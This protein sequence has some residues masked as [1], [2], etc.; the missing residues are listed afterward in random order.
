MARQRHLINGWYMGGR[1]PTGSFNGPESTSAGAGAARTAV[2][3]EE[4]PTGDKFNRVGTAASPAFTKDDESED[5][6][7]LIDLKIVKVM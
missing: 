1:P 4:D 6:F 2:S 3:T 5:Q 7:L